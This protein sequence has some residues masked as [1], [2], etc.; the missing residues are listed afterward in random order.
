MDEKMNKKGVTA[1]AAL[2]VLIAAVAAGVYFFKT[3]QKK[4]APMQMPPMPVVVDKP[5]LRTVQDWFYATGYAEATKSVEVRARVAGELTG[6]E[7]E[8]SADVLKGDL[9]FEI[10]PDVYSARLSQAQ[11][12]V[13]SAK[14]QLESAE[15]DYQRVLSANKANPDSVSAE[16]VSQRKTARDQ[17]AAAL[18]AALADQKTAEINLS[19]TKIYA[20]IDGRVSRNYVDEGNLVGSGEDTLLTTIVSMDELYV[21]FDVSEDVITEHFQKHAPSHYE[22]VRS[23]FFVGAGS[24]EDY[25][26]SGTLDYVDN[27]VEKSTGS[28]KVRGIIENPGK[29]LYPGMYVRI[30]VPVGKTDNAVLIKERA[31][32]TDLSG[33]YVYLVSGEGNIV[34]KANVQCGQ[35]E[36]DMRVILSG[37]SSEDTYIVEGV[38]KAR[39]GAPVSPMPAGAQA[40]AAPAAPAEKAGE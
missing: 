35:L 7:F 20:P 17:A 13:Q 21:Y 31:I 12:Q 1:F 36:G 16:I 9:L 4:P 18:E 27:R 23:E 24:R 8:D 39:P 40:A 2:I 5:E 14:A 26:Y 19:Y 25:P 32:C 15:Q 11:A 38:Q 29:I 22:N 34:S 33:K 28:I 3:G 6:I 10:E 30:K 37:V